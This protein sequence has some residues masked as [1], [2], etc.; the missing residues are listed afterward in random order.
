[1]KKSDKF[2]ESLRRAIFDKCGYDVD[3]T[4][5]IYPIIC[6]MQFL[7]RAMFEEIRKDDKTNMNKMVLEILD[8][9]DKKYKKQQM[10]FLCIIAFCFGLCFSLIL[11]I[12]KFC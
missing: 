9:V 12:I 6:A 11:Y 10:I 2:V 3:S 4:D 8:H 7:A 1:M 5:P